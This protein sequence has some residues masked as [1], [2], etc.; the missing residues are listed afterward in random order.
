MCQISSLQIHVCICIYLLWI[1]KKLILRHTV[2]FEHVHPMSETWSDLPMYT[3]WVRHGL[4]WPCTPYE[5]DTAWFAHVHPMNETQS[6]LT[7]YT[8]WVRHSLIWP[9]TP[10]EWDSLIWPCTPHQWDTIWFDHVHPMSETV[11]FDN[12]HPMSETQ[13]DLTMY[14]LW[15]RHSLIWPCPP[16]EC[17]CH[18][19]R[20]S[21]GLFLFTLCM[22]VSNNNT[23]V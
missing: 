8:L 20:P 21:Y 11:W 14:T 13:Y 22:F 19:H 3:L 18:V 16:D 23:H 6:D 17:I 12:V 7:M 1:T 4:I 10:Y 2:W 5:W 15:M 9:C